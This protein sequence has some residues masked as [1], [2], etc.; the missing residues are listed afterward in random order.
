MRDIWKNRI[1]NSNQQNSSNR[2]DYHRDR[3]RVV[4]SEFF[5]RLQ[6]KTQIFKVGESDLY[7]TRLTHSI[8]VASIG[9]GIITNLLDNLDKKTL[10]TDYETIYQMLSDP[11]LI[12]TLGLAHDIGHPPFGHYG[13]KALNYK[14][15]KH[16]GFEG[17]A[18][19]IRIISRLGEYSE[20]FGMNLTLRSIIG[21]IKYPATY[22]EVCKKTYPDS[23]R[24][25]D[26]FIN[27]EPFIPPKCNF[28]NDDS[29]AMEWI[30]DLL[31]DDDFTMWRKL[32]KRP[33]NEEHGKTI[34]SSFD[35]SIMELA[36]D[37]AYGIYD[38]EDAITYKMMSFDD[39]PEIIEYQKI[40]LSINQNIKKH[41]IASF[42]DLMVKL[43]SKKPYERKEATGILVGSFVHS[44]SII[45][46]QEFKDPLLQFAIEIDPETKELLELMK[47]VIFNKVIKI[48][49]I[50]TLNYNGGLIIMKL[51]DALNSA[52]RDY[53]PANILDSS[54]YDEETKVERKICDYIASMTDTHA[55]R[56][57]SRLYETQSGNINDMI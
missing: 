15:I 17:N 7:R 35:A 3:S 14:M 19:N 24:Y 22:E 1:S 43:F 56:V 36:D 30:N 37:I 48:P 57:Y 31:G 44:A 21:L 10:K 8:E 29:R 51:F 9:S 38:F 6:L 52:P 20:K 12:E 11:Y 28:Y 49:Q 53:I 13:E 45:K 26:H 23:S 32:S 41:G 5:K 46:R 39:C 2:S 55:R 40:P 33:T 50:N 16:G 4:H 34:Y 54:H 25:N 47:T 42:K 18:Q 27:L